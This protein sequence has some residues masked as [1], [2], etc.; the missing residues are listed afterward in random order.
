[1]D[2]ARWALLF[3][4]ERGKAAMLMNTTHGYCCK[5]HRERLIKI[6]LPT[7]LDQVAKWGKT[8][9]IIKTKAFPTC[10]R[11][12]AWPSMHTHTHTLSPHPR[13]N[14]IIGAHFWSTW[15]IQPRA[16]GELDQSSGSSL[17]KFGPTTLGQV[18]ENWLWISLRELFFKQ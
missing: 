3:R 15:S 6:C 2:L 17:S 10:Q 18:P 8:M 5:S 14:A 12:P 11:L 13:T 1:M 4:R 9:N 16:D 7:N